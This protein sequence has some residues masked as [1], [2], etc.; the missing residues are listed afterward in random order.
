MQS[1]TMASLSHDGT[2]DGGTDK[3]SWLA[4]TGV[5]SKKSG[6]WRDMQQS[7]SKHLHAQQHIIIHPEK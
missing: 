6:R 5:R 4:Y 3:G 7:S 2:I 1:V